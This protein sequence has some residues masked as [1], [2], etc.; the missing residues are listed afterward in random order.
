[1]SYP[2]HTAEDKR[3][4]DKYDAEVSMLEDYSFS[5]LVGVSIGRASMC[6]SET[7]RG[8]FDSTKAKMLYDR[9]VQRHEHLIREARAKECDYFYS[10]CFDSSDSVFN[11]TFQGSPR[12]DH[13]EERAKMIRE[14]K[15]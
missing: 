4:K 1:M 12:P 13:F 8:V 11:G 9:I 15:L 5:D 7:P 10:T 3:V 14:G 6:W 2:D